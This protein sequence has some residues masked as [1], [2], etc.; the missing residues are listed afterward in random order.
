[1][2]ATAAP[3]SKSATAVLHLGEVVSTNDEAFRLWRAGECGPLWVLADLQTGG[4]GRSGRA[5]VGGAG[6]LHAS[7]LMTQL[8]P[9]E[10][11]PQLSLVTGVAVVDALRGC[12]CE[13]DLVG[14]RLK[15]PNDI[16]IAGR[17][18]GGILIETSTAAGK[19]AALV[20]GIGLNVVS[21]P[22]DLDRPVT[23][24]GAHG[25]QVEC[26]ELLAAVDASLAAWLSRWSQGGGFAAIRQAW[27]ERAGPVGERVDVDTGRGRIAA[28]FR[29]LDE[30]GALLVAEAGGRIV[31][32]RAGD[33]DLA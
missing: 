5:W 6:N 15:W 7:L 21:H 33:V 19:G 12:A 29:G 22:H 9:P 26:R 30:D 13:A 31:R 23:S 28:E 14:L 4:R 27:C 1:M 3:A 2:P 17:K 16:L 8:A 32:V 10:S 11:Q 24:L 20:I 18:V 25:V